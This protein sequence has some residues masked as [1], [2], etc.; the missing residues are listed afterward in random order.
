MTGYVPGGL[1]DLGVG[2]KDRA[3]DS[4]QPKRPE[5]TTGL[6]QKLDRPA[7]RP[8]LGGAWQR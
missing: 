7:L 2:G 5:L 3:P 6:L 1:G 8:A 4:G